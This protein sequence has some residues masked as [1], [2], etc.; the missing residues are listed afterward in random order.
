MLRLQDF[1]SW[2]SRLRT[3][4]VSMRMGVGSLALLSGLRI[5]RCHKLWCRL[6]MR[7]ESFIA[8]AV[9]QASG[10]SF[11]STPSR[12]SIC[13]RCCPKKKKKERKLQ[14]DIQYDTKFGSL[15]LHECLQRTPAVKHVKSQQFFSEKQNRCSV[16][17]Y[18]FPLGH[19]LFSLLVLNICSVSASLGETAGNKTRSLLQ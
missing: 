9:V 8:V 3:R 11:D 2:L 12:T 15:H 16:Y 13:P 14:K 19:A 17:A 18:Y 10:Y 1:Q 7:L 5:W 4:L 6:P